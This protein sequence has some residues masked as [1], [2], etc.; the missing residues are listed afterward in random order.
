MASLYDRISKGNMA[1]SEITDSM[2]YATS[3]GGKFYQSM[4]K[5]SKTLNGQ[6]ST[7]KDNAMQLLGSITEGM[8]E[9][10]ASQ[11]LPMV[12][13]IVGELQTAFDE[14]GYQ[15]LL[16]TATD[17]LPDLMGM[18][19]GKLQD[20][21]SGL[22]RWLP[23][24]VSAIMSTLPS[25][26]KGAS[27][28]LPQITTALFDTASMVVNDLI[29][30]L[31]EL[32]PALLD[33]IGNMAASLAKGTLHMFFSVFNGI[34]NAIKHMNQ[35]FIKDGVNT[36][37]LKN[38]DFKMDVD[39]DTSAATSEIAK[40]YDTIREALQTDL[41]TDEQKEEIMSMLGEDA[42]A[43]KSKLME[44]GLSEPEAQG[45]ADQISSGGATIVDA[46]NAL[47]LGV[48]AGT[49]AKWFVQAKG[50]NVALRHFAE[51]A[52]LDDDDVDAII[53]VY[54][55]ANGRLADETPSVAETIYDA[56]TDG[57]ADDEE[58][59]SGLKAKVEAWATDR[60]TDI[61]EGYNAAL[62]KLDPTAPDYEAKVA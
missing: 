21:I 32:V 16:D 8:S 4:E 62:K 5:Q 30:M 14:G 47:N 58:T 51:M 26:I 10:L 13:N 29:T 42:D 23:Q 44:F 46:L 15:G 24:G 56:L 9:N 34:G 45:I 18:M 54:N 49:I 48:D 12:N 59:V 37:A 11:M 6:L 27:A 55:E 41:L 52:G 20:A 61:E 22:S 28:V 31:P 17:M 57:L 60:M 1:V 25:A 7:L 35:E 3:E 33:G 2:R 50:S 40:A 19:T 39:V 36:D 38:L 43:I 53:G